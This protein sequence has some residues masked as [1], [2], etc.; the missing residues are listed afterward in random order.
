MSDL[1]KV[2]AAIE[3]PVSGW[4]AEYSNPPMG[5]D[6]E[7]Y[8]KR[9]D[10]IAGTS[11]GR[12]IL[13]LVWGGQEKVRFYDEWDEHNA[14][15]SER[16]EPKY[17]VRR[18]FRTVEGYEL[19][20]MR[21]WVIEQLY[22]WEQ[23]GYG[24]DEG[25]TFTDEHGQVKKAFEKERDYYTPLIYVGDHSKCPKDCCER[26]LCT[27]D[28]KHPNEA[29][30]YWILESTYH[31]QNDRIVD[32]RGEKMSDAEL[33]KIGIEVKDL[34]QKKKEDLEKRLDVITI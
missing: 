28:Y 27:G 24:S 18:W 12:S 1:L 7:A 31:L 19:L 26:K 2:R 16:T 20:P 13:R 8:Q 14:P 17:K 32:P 10:A 4:T 11:R 3:D 15:I 6:R 5:F 22:E 25:T 21:R 34:A 9:I 29:E 30:L 23:Y 33:Q